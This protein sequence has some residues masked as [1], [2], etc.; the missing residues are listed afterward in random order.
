MATQKS[1]T[2][3]SKRSE[4]APPP[5][6]KVLRR[7]R[8]LAREAR[9]LIKRKAKKV[10]VDRSRIVEEA[11]DRV[12]ELLPA[13][14]Q[15]SDTIDRDALHRATGT[16]DG[17]LGDVFG[18]WRKSVGREY[19]ESIV[20]AIGL[21]FIIRAFIFEAFSIPSSSM[22]PTLKIGD[23]LF[24][25]KI[26]YGLFV[27]FSPNR[28][29]HWSQPTRGD[30]IVFEYRF[31]GGRHDG[32][33]FIKRVVA[34]AG[35][36]IRV[37]NNRIVLNGEP[38]PTTVVDPSSTEGFDGTCGVYKQDDSDVTSGRCRCTRQI[39]TLG[40]GDDRSAWTTEYVSQ[41]FHEGGHC[42]EPVRPDWDLSDVRPFNR[43]LFRPPACRRV[44]T[45]QLGALGRRIRAVCRDH[46]D[47]GGDLV[48]PDGH[49]FVMGDN[50][51]QSDDGRSWGLVPYNRIK[52][53]AFFIWY[54]RDFSRIFT[55][56]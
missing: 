24:V 7:A 51:D 17:A 39:E 5:L 6:K 45:D 36:R 26:G 53:T 29:I 21:A 46:Y 27:P 48:V 10:S 20:W 42:L 32:E 23:H 1:R 9:T 41:H 31:P 14:K 47:D 33:D 34:V 30:I 16:L 43:E 12:I 35:D 54:A 40:P 15:A 22:M 25:N 19:L 52:G 2:S 37:D 18:P 56:L 49:V 13:R 44:T 8:D 3:S 55:S 38:I 28:M 4:I 11:L 50:R